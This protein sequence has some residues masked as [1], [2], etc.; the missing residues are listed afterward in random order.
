MKSILVLIVCMVAVTGICFGEEQGDTEKGLGMIF[1]I[2]VPVAGVIALIFA[3]FKSIWIKKQDPG[4][5]K[6]QEILHSR[7]NEVRPYPGAKERTSDS[8]SLK[9]IAVLSSALAAAALILIVVLPSF[10]KESGANM[11]IDQEDVSLVRGEPD[12]PGVTVLQITGKPLNGEPC[13]AAH[14]QHVRVEAVR[15]CICSEVAERNRCVLGLERIEAL[16]SRGDQVV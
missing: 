10:K 15:L 12:Q 6:M 11:N 3:L 16:K 7:S 4:T 2:G 14:V 8:F 5:E 9:K 1:M 13:V